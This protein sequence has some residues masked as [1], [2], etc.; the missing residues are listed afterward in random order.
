MDGVIEKKKHRDIGRQ[1]IYSQTVI[2]Y[3]AE[4]FIF[5][6]N[7]TIDPENH[8]PTTIKDPIYSIYDFINIS[9]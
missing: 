7:Y 8:L 6:K 4:R 1:Q 5:A 3:S 9:H 2:E